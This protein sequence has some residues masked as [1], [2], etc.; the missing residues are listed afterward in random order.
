MEKKF[1]CERNA[2][3]FYILVALIIVNLLVLNE[4]LSFKFNEEKI[5]EEFE[6]YNNNYTSSPPAA[7]STRINVHI[8]SSPTIFCMIVANPSQINTRVGFLSL[9]ETVITILI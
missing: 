8:L 5:K 7:V 3:C 9:K 6:S 1:L 4:H 2:I